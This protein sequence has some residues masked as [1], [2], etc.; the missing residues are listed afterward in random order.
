MKLL[1]INGSPNGKKG[2]SDI[3]IKKM[4]LGMKN[5]GDIKYVVQEDLAK[6]AKEMLDYEMII[7]VMPLYVFAMP[8]IV[9]RLFEEMTH[10]YT[11]IR[12]GFVVQYG[13]IEGKFSCYLDQYLK[14]YSTS[15]NM[16]YMGSVYRGGSA[17]VYVMPEKMNKK[18]FKRLSLLGESIEKNLQFDQSI[19]D[20][21]MQPYELTKFAAKKYQLLTGIGMTNL[22]WNS[23]LKSNK[24]FDKRFDAPY[25]EAYDKK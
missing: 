13:F 19:V 17:G 3:F 6:L 11:G 22:F 4:Q 2:N 16:D 5:Q 14:Q 1:W 15:L 8:G 10:D 18:L 7:I 23:C 24:A 25:G 12:I 21:F 20:E 9:M